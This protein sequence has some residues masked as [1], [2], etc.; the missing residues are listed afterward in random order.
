MPYSAHSGFLPFYEVKKT[1]EVNILLLRAEQTLQMH[2]ETPPHVIL[3]S[4][5]EV[6]V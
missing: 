2:G 6:E 3:L 5:N 1:T 4:N